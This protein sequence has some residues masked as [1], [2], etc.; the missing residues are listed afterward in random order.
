MTP[1]RTLLAFLLLF[2]VSLL[3]PA[4]SAA[5]T[6]DDLLPVDDAFVL[7][8]TAPA[9]DRIE[10]RWKITDGYYLYRHRTGVDADTGFAAQPLQLPKGK[11]YRDEFFGDVETYRGELVATLPGRPAAGTDSVSL[12]IKY[13]GCADAGICY[14]PQTRTLKV[15]LPPA[16]D[17]AF[18][19]L[20]TGATGGSLLG[21]K[22]QTGTDALPMP[23]EQA[24]AFE[25]IAFD[26]NQLLLRFT[27]ARG[28]Y[29]YRDRTSMALEGASGVSLQAPHWPK[30]VAHHDEHFGDVTVYFDQAEVPVPLK[31]DRAN[32]L[33][34][35][36]R[37]TFQGCQTDGICYPPMTRRVKLAIPAGTVTPADA[38]V[39]EAPA[40]VAPVA[41][42]ADTPAETT[43]EEAPTTTTNVE[44]TRPPKNVVANTKGY[45]SISL[46]TAFAFALLGGLVLNLMPCVLPILSLK[47]LSLAESGRGGNDARHRALWYT[48]GVLV[49]FIAVG[50]IAIAL[51][52]AG[53]ALGWGFQLQQPWVVGVLAYIMFAVGLSLSGVFTVG[54]RLAGAGHGL[55]TRSGP[56]GDFFTG[57]L[58]VVVASPCTAPFMGVAL[59]YAFTA[60][61]VLGLLV[62]A[63][64]GLGLALPFLLIGFVPALANR[65]PRP[66]VWMET[67][68]QVLAF[69]MYLT[70]AWLLWVL[71]NQR[72]VDAIGLALAGLVVLTLGLWWWQRLQLRAAPLQRVLAGL[73]VVA[74]VLPLVVA[75]RMP[76]ASTLTPRSDDHVA[77]SAEALGSLRAE[78]RIV[79]VD[80]TADWCVTCKANEKAVLNTSAFRDLLTAHDAVMMTGDWTNVDPA[81]TAFLEEHGAVGV[82]LYVMYPRGGGAGE[83]LPTVLTQ[84]GMRQAF[85]RAAR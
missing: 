81:I 38:V 46:L 10:I 8:A 71:G 20:G 22:P 1:I 63:V 27:P 4:A 50:A 43:T 40:V 39:S 31:R 72:G 79:F 59:A 14:P 56:A 77:Y 26:G 19:P 30:G 84:D 67:L 6:Q 64:L 17:E 35:T 66:G 78:G 11:A 51:R 85:E 34:A 32:A 25:A 62:F 48:A 82:P 58:A 53:Q 15:A 55:A 41:T 23:A 76:K 65:L 37:V 60:P 12:K 83:V 7:T 2:L 21:P 13:Q 18:V 16:E 70:A 74:S 3:A 52:Y 49:S 33:N 75:H 5:I 36:L 68:K 42:P 44:R 69:P 54:H 57:V 29:V 73:L 61:G 45:G 80:M 28:Y 9:R 47:A 24:F